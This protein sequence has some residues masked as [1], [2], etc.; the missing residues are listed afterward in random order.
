MPKKQVHIS[1]A[2][3]YA[4]VQSNA[5]IDIIIFRKKFGNILIKEQVKRQLAYG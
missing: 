2:F 5:N 4:Q 1:P 3:L